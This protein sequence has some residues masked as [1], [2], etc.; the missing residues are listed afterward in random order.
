MLRGNHLSVRRP[1]AACRPWFESGSVG[2]KH[3]RLAERSADGVARFL[4]NQEKLPDDLAGL[5]VQREHMALPT[6]EVAARVADVN[7]AVEGDRRRWNGLAA[8]RVGDRRLPDSF[9]SLEVIG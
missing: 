5:R 4:G 1:L 3:P 8:F 6:F 9:A 2:W 7:E